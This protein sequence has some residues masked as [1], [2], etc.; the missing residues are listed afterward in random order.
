MILQLTQEDGATAQCSDPFLP[1]VGDRGE[2]VSLLPAL[3]TETEFKSYL[4][5][6]AEFERPLATISSPAPGRNLRTSVGPLRG[7]SLESEG[8]WWAESYNPRRINVRARRR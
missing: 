5:V 8:P 4:K 1:L 7:P 6:S 2:Q 3:P